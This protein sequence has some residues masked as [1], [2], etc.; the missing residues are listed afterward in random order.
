MSVLSSLSKV[1]ISRA[2]LKKLYFTQSENIK[3]LV[4][5]V[6]NN[7]TDIL[8]KYTQLQ[9]YWSEIEFVKGAAFLTQ[10]IRK[11]KAASNFNQSI[12]I[13][14]A[15]LSASNRRVLEQYM[16]CCSL[17]A[18]ALDNNNQYH[19]IG[20][21]RRNRN[22]WHENLSSGNGNALTGANDNADDNKYTISF[23]CNSISFAPHFLGDPSQIVITDTPDCCLNP[24]G[25]NLVSLSG[26][27]LV[28]L[29]GECLTS[30]N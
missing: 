21:S 29:S 27:C 13:E 11:Q 1:C 5:D 16:N 24:V 9:P 2:G 18:I 14:I 17:N 30:I 12:Q 10:N 8:L 7:I 25:V 26:K 20:I 23:N 6:H 15:K 28:N 3:D 22:W 19:Y 4:F